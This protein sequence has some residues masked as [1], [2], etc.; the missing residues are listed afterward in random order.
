VY[1][2]RRG[3]P[4]PPEFTDHAIAPADVAELD[5]AEIDA[6]RERWIDTWTDLVLR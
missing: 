4:L 2:V 1:P 3:T 5:P 6:S